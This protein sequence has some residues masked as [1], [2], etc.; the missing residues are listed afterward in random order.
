MFHATPED[1]KAL[2]RRTQ[3]YKGMNKLEEALRDAK[4]LLS[5]DPKNKQFIEYIQGLNKVIQDK[6]NHPEF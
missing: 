1:T 4:R 3:A 5:L 2:Y 6:V